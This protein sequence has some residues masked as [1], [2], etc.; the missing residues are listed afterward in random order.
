[1]QAAGLP[2]VAAVPAVYEEL[3]R[4]GLV[5]VGRAPWL[6]AWLMPVGVAHS[7]GL[8]VL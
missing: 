4:L 5:E 3:R 7:T 6:V 8:V 1:M 2:Y